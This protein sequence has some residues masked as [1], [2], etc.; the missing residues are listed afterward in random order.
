MRRVVRAPNERIS[1]SRLVST[2]QTSV[3]LRRVQQFMHEAD[4]LRWS[5]IRNAPRLTATMGERSAP[6][7]NR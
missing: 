1:A 4:H 2:Y 6:H 3:G 5:R 7:R